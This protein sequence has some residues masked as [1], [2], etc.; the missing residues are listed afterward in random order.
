MTDLQTSFAR[1]GDVV[2]V[3][4]VA[5]PSLAAPEKLRELAR[6][7]GAVPGRWTFVAGMPPFPGDRFV[8]VDAAGRLRASIADSDPA[9]ASRLLDAA[10]D[11]LRERHR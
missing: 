4:F 5:D 7:F 9:L 2:L 6:T 11:L 3:T 8:A 10:G 1:A